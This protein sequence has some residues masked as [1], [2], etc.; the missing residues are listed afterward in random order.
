MAIGSVIRAAVAVSAASALSVKD[1]G[2]L[3]SDVAW[4]RATNLPRTVLVSKHADVTKCGEDFPGYFKMDGLYWL[5]EFATGARNRT[6][7]KDD[8]DAAKNCIGFTALKSKTERM[9]C[10]L[11]K[12]LQQQV[13][14]RAVSFSKCQIKGFACQNGFQ[15]SH[16]GTWRSGKQI[17]ELDDEALDACAKA[18]KK[19]K[20][21]VG[22]THRESKDGDTYCFHFENEENRIGAK[23]NQHAHTYAKCTNDLIDDDSSGS[24]ATDDQTSMTA[25]ATEFLAS[26]T[27]K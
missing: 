25:N 4:S 1:Q 13:D 10:S 27:E 18:C 3:G 26:V 21:C 11:H 19:D 7:C 14:H 8:C 17:E 2:A 23:R 22:F 5:S 6:A 9:R 16:A 15:F 12:G 24:N 20:G